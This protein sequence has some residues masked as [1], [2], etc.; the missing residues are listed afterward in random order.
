MMAHAPRRQPTWTQEW[1]E[2]QRLIL[3]PWNLMEFTLM[4]ILDQQRFYSFHFLPFRMWMFI[5]CLS[6]YCTLKPDNFFSSFTGSQM[7]MNFA[8]GGILPRLSP[9]DDLDYLD[10]E[11]WNFLS[12]L[13]EILELELVFKWIKTFETLDGTNV[14]RAWN[15]VTFCRPHIGLHWAE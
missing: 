15:Y 14:F 9:I 4:D 12:Y 13:F 3:R 1:T 8:P 7:V 10:F 5:L 6:H 11:N 2:P